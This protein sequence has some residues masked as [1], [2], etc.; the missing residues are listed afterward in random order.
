MSKTM[1]GSRA[2]CYVDNVLVGIWE[3]VTTSKSIGTEAI[4]LMGRYSAAEIAITSQEV[5]NVSCSGFRV[6]GNGIHVLPKVPMVQDL[7]TFE[8]FTIVIVDRQT[9]ETIKTIQQCTPTTDNDNYSAKATSKVSVNYTGIIAFD[10][11]GAQSEGAGAADL[12]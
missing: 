6:V 11:S 1:V 12:P 2:L 7:L 10:E 9:G 5:C 4:H 3:S 8:P